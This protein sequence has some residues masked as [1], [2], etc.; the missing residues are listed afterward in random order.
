MNEA[1]DCELQI[2]FRDNYVNDNHCNSVKFS[3][4]IACKHSGMSILHISNTI[5]QNMAAK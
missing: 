2:G 3:A 5:E 1:T 4:R